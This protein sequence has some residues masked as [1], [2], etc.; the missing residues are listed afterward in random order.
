[1]ALFRI[2][3]T[4]GGSIRV[5]GLNIS[6]MP[7]SEVRRHIV[8][9]PQHAFLL[10]GSVRLNID[11]SGGASDETI[12]SALVCVQMMDC[13]NKNGGLDSDVDELNL[14]AG[15]K[16]L[17]CLARAM[18]R[19]GKIVVLDEVTSSVDG[20][21]EDTV[22]KLIRRKYAAHTIIAVTHRLDTIMDFDRVV[23]MDKGRVVEVGRPWELKAMDQSWFGRLWNESE[24]EEK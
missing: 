1:M 21:T 22:H 16:Q 14:S 11:P 12:R 15:Q 3:D 4:K 10:K 23:V 19:P 17:F 24:R 5:D 2:V 18:V 8:G 7:R 20:R 6:T 13:V 9:V